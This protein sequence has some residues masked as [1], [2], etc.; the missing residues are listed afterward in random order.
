MLR[1]LLIAVVLLAL[2][3]T[4]S[5]SKS[6][7]DK[8]CHDHP[9]LAG[10][11]FRVHGRLS[12]FNGAPALRLTN[13]GTKRVLGISEQRFAIPG[14]RNVPEEVTANIDQDK[15][16]IGDYLVCPFTRQRRGEMQMVCIES[17]SRLEVRP[18]H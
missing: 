18:S 5:S 14:Y 11:C 8:S 4:A 13:L 15:S 7:E 1:V 17:V 12:V 16:L 6:W 10:K 3:P 2:I 9:Q